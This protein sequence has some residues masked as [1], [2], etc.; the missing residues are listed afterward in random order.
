MEW[1]AN[2]PNLNPTE[3]LW[4]QLEFV[5]HA[6][7]TNTTTVAHLRQIL[8]EEW[9]VIPTATLAALQLSRP[10]WLSMILPP[11]TEVLYFAQ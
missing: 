6:R 7:V 3:H 1:P 9:D 4:D 10:L 8:V 2:S 5:V 11:T